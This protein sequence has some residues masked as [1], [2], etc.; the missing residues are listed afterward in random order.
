MLED[1]NKQ[2]SQPQW[3]VFDEPKRYDEILEL[4]CA[5]VDQR[6]ANS[7]TGQ[8]TVVVCQH[9]PTITLGKRSA[10]EHLIQPRQWFE[11]NGVE[12]LTVDRGGSVTVHEPGQWVCYPILRLSDYGLSVSAYVDALVAWIS[13]VCRRC[14]VTVSAAPW[15]PVAHPKGTHLAGVWVQDRKVASVG[16]G[17]KQGVT[18]HGVA[19]NVNND[20]KLFDAVVPCGIHG[21]KTTSLS[22]ELGRPLNLD[23]VVAVAQSLFPVEIGV[24]TKTKHPTWPISP[25]V[26]S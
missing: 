24:P 2:P 8:D 1:G 26:D 4:Q 5:L 15:P 7:K 16:I 22:K 21:L 18:M 25:P 19:L 6:I 20:G 23:A 14:G 11:Q 17:V 10:P 12:V 9:P 13:A 3:R